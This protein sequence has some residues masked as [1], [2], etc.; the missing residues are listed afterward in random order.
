MKSGNLKRLSYLLAI[1]LIGT[2]AITAQILLARELVSI[3]SGNELIYGLTIFLWLVLYSCGSGLIGRLSRKINNKLTAFIALQGAIALLLPFEIFFVRIIKNMLGIPFGALVGLGAIAFIIIAVLAPITLILGFQFAL[4]SMLLSETF[5]RDSSQ[6]SRVYIF[7]AIGSIAGGLLFTY[8]LIFF[9]NAFQIAA[10]LAALV[11]SSLILIGLNFPKKHVLLSGGGILIIAAAILLLSGP[12]NSSSAQ[13]GLGPFRLIKAA[14]SP[15]G[16]IT[17]SEYNG[18][19]NFYQSGNLLF[20]SQ[21]RLGSEEIAHLSLLLHPD[22]RDILLIG[23][24]ASGITGEIKKY[25]LSSLTILELDYKVIELARKFGV[26]DPEIGILTRDGVKYLSETEKTYDIILIDLPDPTTAQINRFYTLEFIQKCR[27]R[28]KR[29][30]ILT[31]H[32]ETSGS[33]MGRELKLLNQSIY[34]TT[35]AVFEH[36]LVI[37]GNYN[38][39]FA[40][41]NE[42][43]EKRS[44]LINRWRARNIRTQFFRTDSLFYIL[45][46]D[47]IKYVREAINFDNATPVNTEYK[48]VSYYFG[49]LIWASYFYAPVKDLFYALMRI[50]FPNLLFIVIAAL[51]AIKLISLKIKRIALPTLIAALGFTAMCTQLIIV[52]A[53]QSFYGYVYQTIGLLTT[54]FMAGL[55]AGSFLIYRQYDQIKD[56]AKMLKNILWLLL[57]NITL[58]FMLL[59]VIPLPLAPFLISLPI[60]AAFPL[61]VKIH[62]KYRSEI[63]GLAGILYGSDLLG[64]GLAAIMTTIFLIPIFGILNTFLVAITVAAGALIIS[65]S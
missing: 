29:N 1:A 45:W 13:I 2:A 39:F 21:D 43:P 24:G 17:V 47:K 51:L 20:T 5:R 54:V 64:G 59:R 7:E 37:P 55:A 34:K 6:I 28:L 27:E 22:P 52:Y 61:A 53:F 19:Y 9:L 42:I 30:G 12:L 44:T 14:D 65:Y 41:E 38:Y 50:S 3:F 35:S 15:F 40:S 11:A 48:P 25:P 36:V 32:L 49:L 23:G 57:M 60:G 31:F 10:L 56:P 33:Y 4:G 8:I 18:A 58:I 46:P 16:R 62:E 26:L 63:G